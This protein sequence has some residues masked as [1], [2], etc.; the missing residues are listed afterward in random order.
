MFPFFED[1][2]ENNEDQD[3]N[4]SKLALDTKSS[5]T[6]TLT[7]PTSVPTNVKDW[8]NITT[9]VDQAAMSLR[10]NNSLSN[11]ANNVPTQLTLRPNTLSKSA[12]DV[13]TT[14]PTIQR[15]VGFGKQ[16]IYFVSDNVQPLNKKNISLSVSQ[17]ALVTPPNIYYEEESAGPSHQTSNNSLDDENSFTPEA[18]PDAS[19]VLKTSQEVDHEEGTLTPSNQTSN[20]SF[21]SA[22]FFP[23]VTRQYGNLG[24]N[25]KNSENSDEENVL[26]MSF[27]D[28]SSEN[29][30]QSNEV[31]EQRK[32]QEC[33][34]INEDTVQPFE[35][36]WVTPE[37]SSWD[38][39]Y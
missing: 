14:S 28:S 15:I 23:R 13:P 25:K 17:D 12:G 4:Y 37:D 33:L 26:S 20:N 38:L 19:I 5:S 11:S 1:D 3:E 9:P 21:G 18:V 31:P 32:N 7:L 6:P 30:D 16:K 34:T 22:K 35:T 10:T 24:T 27:L 36:T 2:D 39:F 29:E 8:R